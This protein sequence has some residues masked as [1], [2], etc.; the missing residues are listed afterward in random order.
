[1]KIETPRDEARDTTLDRGAAQGPS[2][3]RTTRRDLAERIAALADEGLT[4]GEIGERLAMSRQRVMRVAAQFK[5]RLQPRGGSRRIGVQFNG[6]RYDILKQLAD[7]AGISVGAI[8]ARLAAV[9]VDDGIVVAKKRLGRHAL[10][11]RPY[12]RRAR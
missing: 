12:T 1:M 7:D 3:E 8:I 5:I 10:P 9:V 2:V 4:A 11:K 6:A